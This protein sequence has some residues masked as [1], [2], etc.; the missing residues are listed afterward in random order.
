MNVF[1]HELRRRRLSTMAWAL[2][3]GML[4]LLSILK[5]RTLN[6]A[7]GTALHE[8][9]SSFPQTVQGLFGMNGL[10]LTMI[11][12]Y[13]AV[14]FLFIAIALAVHA[15]L[16]GVSVLTDEERD[17]TTE[18]LYSKPYSRRRIMSAKLLAG[19]VIMVVVWLV[20]YIS[21]VFSIQSAASMVGFWGTLGLMMQALGIIQL[22]FFALGACSA[23]LSIRPTSSASLV[24]VI[25][26][27]S[28]LCYVAA[29]LSY[30]L[31]RMHYLS[32]FS[33]FDAA[34]I[35]KSGALKLHY[36]LIC[37]VLTFATAAIT[38]LQYPRRDLRP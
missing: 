18:F 2:S 37:V 22:T 29:R 9:L 15:G 32:I 5:Y 19:V 30:S 25:I 10:D 26:F 34:D 12:G 4:I 31:D 23:T 3:L 11:S 20:T 16:L 13:F 24:T 28:Y 27:I 35:V 38:Y 36:I 7:G 17:R 6:S 8:M 33:Y 1:W 14:C 21:S